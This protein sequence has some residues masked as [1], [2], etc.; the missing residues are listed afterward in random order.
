MPSREDQTAMHPSSGKSEIWGRLLHSSGILNDDRNRNS[1]IENYR[2]TTAAITATTSTL[3]EATE[4]F[5]HSANKNYR[6]LVG[7]IKDNRER[8]AKLTAS[9]EI[10]SDNAEA[11]SRARTQYSKLYRADQWKSPRDEQ[12]YSEQQRITRENLQRTED[13]TAELTR[14]LSNIEENYIQMMQRQQQKPKPE[15]DRGMDFGM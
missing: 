10:I 6:D 13:C 7:S 5:R 8:S 12:D 1:I 3:A 14:N 9:T 2:R 11:I 4:H 15:Q